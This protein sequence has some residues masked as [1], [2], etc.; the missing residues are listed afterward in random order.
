[1]CLI[2]LANDAHP[3]YRLILAANRDEF[4]NRPTAS[5]GYWED[6]PQILAGRDL[7]DGGTWLGITRSGEIAALTNF[8]DPGSDHRDAPSRGRL[9]S[10]FLNGSRSMEEY[11]ETL[12]YEG[13]SYNGFNLIFGDPAR[14]CWYCNRHKRERF[15]AAGIHGLSNSL[16]DSP[17]PKVSRGKEALARII[18]EGSEIGEEQL[19]SLLS[20][21]TLPPDGE[22]PDTGVGFELELLLSPIFISSP[23]YGTR[24]STVILVDRKNYV[25]F[26]ERSFNGR[27]EKPMDSRWRFRIG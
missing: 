11:L 2:L 17:W 24:S 12:R 19:L 14:L 6:A 16:L 13:R 23:A 18:E 22:L 9:V 8:R 5:A 10:G 25:T 20:D 1:M 3:I 15:L 21:R 4:Y 7:K 26:V 27:P